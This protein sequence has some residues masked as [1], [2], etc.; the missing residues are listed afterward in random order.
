MPLTRRS[1]A[2]ICPPADHR[3]G[4]RAEKATDD[5]WIEAHSLLMTFRQPVN[6]DQRFIGDRG[7]ARRIVSAVGT[8]M[9]SILAHGAA[10]ASA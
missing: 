9:R 2:A 5:R 1:A 8:R 3:P 10:Q 7:V 4:T 6:V